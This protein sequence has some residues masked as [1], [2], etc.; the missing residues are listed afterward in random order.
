MLGFD[1]AREDLRDGLLDRAF[2]RGLILLGAGSRSLRF[3]PRYDTEP[4]A[5]DEALAIV[6]ASVE[7][8]LGG[9]VASESA[10]PKIRVGTL[11]APLDT[12]ETIELTPASFAECKAQIM[13]VEQERYG[14]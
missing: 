11:A 6:Q 4:Y 10:G 8:L 7:D 14:A 13:V 3:Y 5:I 9:R 12:L 2:R 1:V